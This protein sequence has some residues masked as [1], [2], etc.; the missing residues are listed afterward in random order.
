MLYVHRSERS[1]RLVEMLGDLLADPLA[2]AMTPEVVAVPT[3]GVERW[4]S[5]RLSHRLGTNGA[6]RDGVCA[7]VAFPFP[8]TLVGQATAVACG[9]GRD[10]DP[11]LPARSVWPLLDVVDERVEEPWLAMLRDHLVAAAPSDRDG[12]RRFT[13]VRHLA[14]LY[15]H[16]GV[17]RPELILDWAAGAE[18]GWQGELWRHLRRRIGTDSPAERL[19]PAAARLTAEPDL[20]ELPR[21]LSL[22]GLTRLPASHL[23]VLEAI[24]ANRDVHLFLLHPSGALWERVAAA[25]PP[26]GGAARR[27][28]DPARRT[29]DPTASLA[30]HPLLRSW[31][32]DAREMQLVLA[33]HGADYG[34]HRP[35]GDPPATLLGRLQADIR[36]DRPP[37]AAGRPGQP[38]LRPRLG[39]DDDSLRVHACHGRMRQVE[40]MRDAILHLLADDPTLEPRDVIVMCPDIESFAPLVH[41]AFDT[42][43]GSGPGAPDAAVAPDVPEI[44]VRLADRSLRQTN[45]LLSVADALLDLAGGRVTAS[46]VLDLAA[47]EPVRRRFRLD[48]DD[49]AQIERWVVD[50][51]VR[52]GFDGDHRDG[53]GLR[54]LAAGTWATG[55]DRLLLGVAMAEEDQRLFGGA[56]PVDDVASASVHLAG[57]LAEL[58]SRLRLAVEGLSGRLPVE[59]WCGALLDATDALAEAAPADMWQRDQLHR[60][61]D[62]VV[63]EARSATSL[64]SRAEVRALL[65]H[66]LQGQPTRANFRTG[67]LTICTLVPM[68]SVPHRVVGLLGL[69]DGVFPR[70]PAPDGDDVLL[71]DPHVGDRDPRS[72]DR[73]LLLDAL[74]AATDHL[75]VTYSGRDDRT[76]APRPPAVPMAELLDVVDRTVRPTD[77]DGLARVD[78]LVRHPLQPFDP[79]NFSDGCLGQPGPWSFDRVNFAGALALSGPV[80]AGERPW[81]AQ[82][83]P[84]PGGDVVQLDTLVRFVEHPVRAFLRER[85]GISARDWSEE[86]HDALPLELDGLEKWSVGDRVLSARLHGASVE[87]ADLAELARGVLPPGRLGLE[88]LAEIDQ[89]VDAV[90]AAV[91]GLAAAAVTPQSVEVNVALPDGR[92]LIGTADGYRDGTLLRAV[93]SRL[94]PKHRL[95]AWVRFLAV[96]AAFPEVA[97]SSVTV[98]RGRQSRTGQLVGQSWLRPLATTPAERR[99]MALAQLAPLL[100]LYDRGMREPLPIYCATSAAWAR[101]VRGGAGDEHACEVARDEWTKRAL[102]DGEDREPEHLLVLGGA[103]SFDAVCAEEA[104]PTESGP[105]WDEQVPG[106][107]R[108]LALRLWDGLLSLEDLQDR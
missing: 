42:R 56:L 75:V 71:A 3:R 99:A 17:H 39:A 76:N 68:R 108:R 23:A 58:V 98:G 16:Y 95:A 31:G 69:D 14:D 78:V 77:G 66:R 107:F 97:V 32:R 79:R 67:D 34:E 105:G 57:R 88:A 87:R 26:P 84:P 45:P 15:D 54:D 103:T 20:M 101:S 104:G 81:L 4:L 7:N 13:T 89:A 47:R 51:G 82:P 9:F 36:D 91:A 74:L 38:D 2:D 72:E 53:W 61:L 49:L 50:M 63:D 10:D 30:R 48:D 22:F 8:G 102:F 55:L 6:G 11:W 18:G 29:A 59:Q 27:I 94:G 41:A 73:Q 60:V 65:G 28:G 85:L 106:R 43:D 86:I 64:L 96:T 12:L 37:P 33:A 35:V 83:L 92:R 90:A 80:R 19:R 44:R 100:D 70:H 93:Y 24:A 52:W 40:V 21:R 46:Q 25:G 5:Q 1:D 62:E